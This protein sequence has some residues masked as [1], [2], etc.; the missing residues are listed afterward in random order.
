MALW[1]TFIN[2]GAI[3]IGSILG[4]LLPKMNDQI[5]KTVLQG[6]SLALLALGASM[7]LKTG[8]LLILLTSLVLG[9]VVGE[10][11]G[12]EHRLERAGARLEKAVLRFGKWKVSEGFIYATMLFCIGSMS[13][14]GA[15]DSGLRQDHGILYSKAVL[16]GF[17][18]ILFA[19]T[20]GIGVILSA[21]SVF[22]YEG[23]IAAAASLASSVI[24]EM[25]LLAVT[26]EI[27]AVGGVMIMAISF[28]MLDIV[29]IRVASMLPALV[30]AA[31]AVPLLQFLTTLF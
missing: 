7:S 3:I 29:R 31:L 13:I 4:L 25:T 21:L 6:L 23:A 22:I 27:T 14:L 19:S 20:L 10:L 15:L 18:S 24:D 2:A 26:N 28:N 9:G 30:L 16:D 1:G 17:A 12:I 8:N 11:L 5:K